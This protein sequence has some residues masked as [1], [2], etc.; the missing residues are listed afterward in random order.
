M[1]NSDYL[2]ISVRE[3]MLG[4]DWDNR[5]VPKDNFLFIFIILFWLI[6]FPVTLFV[7]GLLCYSIAEGDLC[8]TLFLSVWLLFGWGGVLLIPYGLLGRWTSEWIEISP[9][10][11]THGQRGLW[12]PKPRTFPFADGV[13]LL[14]GYYWDESVRMLHLI[15]EGKVLFERRSLVGYWLNLR[16]KEEVF[17]TI[18]AFVQAHELALVIKRNDR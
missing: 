15:S 5:R 18:E 17:Q 6:W 16:L 13:Q 2:Q 11:I 8:T 9:D 10:S 14:F 4:I 7:T 12:Y 1:P 3:N